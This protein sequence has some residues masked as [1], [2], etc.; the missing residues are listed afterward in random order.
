LI[1]SN[2]LSSSKIIQNIK[3]K[4]VIHQFFPIDSNFLI[5]R[6]LNYWKPSKA[7][8]IDSEFWPN[9]IV[10]LNE[11]KI[12]IILL[13]GRITSRTFH[14]WK[15]F[16]IL[17]KKLFSNFQFSFASNSESKNYLK[18]LNFNNVKYIGNLKYS[19]SIYENLNSNRKLKE[20][21]KKRKSWC[22]ASTHDPEELLVAEVHKILK[23]KN[24]K[25]LTIIIPRHAE[26][27]DKIKE[28]LEKL[29]LKV[30]L[31][32]DKKKITSDTDIYLINSYGKNKLF[33]KYCKNIFLGGSLINHGGQNPLEAARYGC[34]I[35]SGSHVQNFREIYN[36][37][38]KNKL[39][40]LARN[41]K[42]LIF[43]LK[44]LLNNKN[45]IKKSNNKIK[46]IGDQ[47][48]KKTYN[49]IFN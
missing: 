13:N 37:L 16:P 17:T 32:T 12:P 47:I 6:F 27:Y 29:D 26:R 10:N 5:K 30:H 45:K 28:N 42:A 25:L 35:L 24:K 21:F 19:Q 20:L 31:F 14:R 46:D 36:F 49:L 39:Y 38:K 22:A 8:F 40:R 3:Q 43:E 44:L 7:L 15:K 4:K 1:T 48:L 11:N 23:R 41:K 2:T 33:Y 9:T 34:S 18:K